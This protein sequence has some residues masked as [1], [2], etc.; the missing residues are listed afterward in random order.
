[1][2]GLYWVAHEIVTGYRVH[3]FAH[4]LEKKMIFALAIVKKDSS[5]RIEVM[6]YEFFT[7]KYQRFSI[8]IILIEVNHKFY[9]FNT[10]FALQILFRHIYIILYMNYKFWE[11]L[12]LLIQ[13]KENKDKKKLI[14][15]NTIFNLCNFGSF[16][17]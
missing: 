17:N 7:I 11:V 9:I 2:L 6:S 13:D 15:V 10:F 1:M 5:C 3:K 12:S 16:I 8:K 4:L 14:K